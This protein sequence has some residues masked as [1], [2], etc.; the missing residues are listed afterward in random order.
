[1]A[2]AQAILDDRQWQIFFKKLDKNIHNPEKI[3]ATA[4]ATR[5]FRDIQDHFRNEEGPKG[6]WQE[7]SP[8]RLRQR[9][10]GA[11]ILQDTGNLRQSITPTNYKKESD[12]IR[13]FAAAPYSGIHDR[14][15]E[16]KNI[17]K[18]SFMWLSKQALS[19]MAK[20]VLGLLTK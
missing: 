3:L 16:G 10:P 9:G 17:P 6:A 14:G 5:G 20:I 8:A 18:R 4:Y 2:E 11:R 12:G 7:L 1:M 13:V 15:S 19:D